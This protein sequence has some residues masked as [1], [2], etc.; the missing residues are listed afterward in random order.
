MQ[1][2]VVGVVIIELRND[3]QCGSSLSRGEVV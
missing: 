3:L 1:S 2:V